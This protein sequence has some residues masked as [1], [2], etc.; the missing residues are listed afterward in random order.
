MAAALINEAINAYDN[1]QYQK[2]LDLYKSAS[3]TPGGDQLRAYNG[4]SI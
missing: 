3:Q 2:S 4:I 1:G